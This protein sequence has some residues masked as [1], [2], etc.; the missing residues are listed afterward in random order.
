MSNVLLIEPNKVLANVYSAALTDV[1]YTVRT[2][3]TAQTALI[4]ADE[5]CPDVVVMELQL[6]AHSGVEF[7]YEFRSYADWQSIPVIVHTQISP[8]Q[9]GKSLVAARQQFGIVEYLYKP[10]TDLPA[11]LRAVQD[12]AVVRS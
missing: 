6:V 3:A 1:G 12:T 7:L 9:H 5:M 10:L 4:A 11:L 8:T 2:C